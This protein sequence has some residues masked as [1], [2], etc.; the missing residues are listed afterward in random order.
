MTVA[1]SG[2]GGDEL[3]AGYN[4]YQLTQ[5]FWRTLALLPR[6]LRNGAAAGLT[7][8][9]PD[10]W[11]SILSALPARLRPPQAGD[12][13]HKA[14]SVLRLEGPDAIHSRLVSHWE[15]AEIMLQARE[16]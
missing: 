4:C 13:M 2:D 1:L 5:R 16:P 7:A 6:W 12:K 15:P 8:L 14:A 11:T 10:R 3:F 9:S